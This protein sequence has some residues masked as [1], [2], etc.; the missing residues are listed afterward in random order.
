[1]FDCLSICTPQNNV[2]YLIF[3]TICNTINAYKRA[4][5]YIIKMRVEENNIV[6]FHEL[7]FHFYYTTL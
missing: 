4:Y 2:Y 1:M 6:Q 5:F 7:S 3:F